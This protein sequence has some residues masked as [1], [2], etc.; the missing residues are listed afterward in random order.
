MFVNFKRKR[1][2]EHPT[3]GKLLQFIRKIN[4]QTMQRFKKKI[5]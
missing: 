4:V 2:R 3:E 1:E 5:M